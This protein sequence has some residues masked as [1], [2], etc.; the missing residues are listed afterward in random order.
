M[1]RVVA[2]EWLWLVGL[3]LVSWPLTVY[4]HKANA[5]Y[6]RWEKWRKAAYSQGLLNDLTTQRVLDGRFMGMDE[7]QAGENM[8]MGRP[9][10]SDI[11]LLNRLIERSRSSPDR[12]RRIDSTLSTYGTGPEPRRPLLIIPAGVDYARQ[13]LPTMWLLL[14]GVIGVC[15]LTIWSARTARRQRPSV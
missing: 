1:K 3:A 13:V 4:V 7:V 2:R 5:Q 11:E 15:R 10:A 12:A 14:Y 9:T 6:T 8:I